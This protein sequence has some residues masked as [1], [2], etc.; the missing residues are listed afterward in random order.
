MD[1]K[2]EDERV[3]HNLPIQRKRLKYQSTK[4]IAWLGEKWEIFTWI[5]AAEA[6]LEEQ[7]TKISLETESSGCGLVIRKGLSGSQILFAYPAKEKERNREV[8]SIHVWIRFE[9]RMRDVV[10]KN[11]G[12]KQKAIFVWLFIPLCSTTVAWLSTWS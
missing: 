5:L 7:E 9:P 4:P 2:T 10:Y 12:V 8:S 11:S 6:D 1:D 3:F